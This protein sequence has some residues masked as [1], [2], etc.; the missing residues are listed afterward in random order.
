M[1]PEKRADV[2][3][4]DDEVETQI[5]MEPGWQEDHKYLRAIV[6]MQIYTS[7]HASMRALGNKLNNEDMIVWLIV[8]VVKLKPEKN[9]SSFI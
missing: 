5:H 7:R 1:A 9:S 8:A 2:H 6:C 4:A 3:K